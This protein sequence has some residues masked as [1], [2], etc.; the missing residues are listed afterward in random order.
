MLCRLS[1]E[2]YAL[3]DRLD[4]EFSA[5]LNIVTGETGAG[6]SILLGALGLVL[7]ARTDVSVLRDGTRNCVIEAE[8]DVRG[9]GLES[10][11]ERADVDYEDRTSIRRV[12]S[13][14]G[15][16]R[17][18]VNDL[19]V[20]LSA[21]RE[22]GLRLID[23]HSQHQTLLLG[24][25]RFQTGIVDAVAGH[26]D[27]LRR[28]GAAFDEMTALERELSLLRQKASAVSYTHL[29]LPTI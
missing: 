17:A 10:L 7:G 5:G 28:Y 2:N 9:H 12:I 23:I 19:P 1:V 24:E 11:F 3:I 21:L 18:Y 22:I 14:S 4:I 27:L 8:F 13:P 20:Q 16:S 6:K 25:G 29:T 15:K 26:A